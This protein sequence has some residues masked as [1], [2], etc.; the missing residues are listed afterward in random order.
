M[1]RREIHVPTFY[2]INNVSSP[3]LLDLYACMLLRY[4]RRALVPLAWSNRKRNFIHSDSA[5]S[6]VVNRERPMEGCDPW[7]GLWLARCLE[8]SGLCCQRR[9]IRRQTE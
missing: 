9:P 8:R 6:L 4:R 3:H 1:C 2:E 5:T 7:Q